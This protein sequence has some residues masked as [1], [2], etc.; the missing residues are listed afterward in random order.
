[1]MLYMIEDIQNNTKKIVDIN[2]FDYQEVFDLSVVEI[3]VLQMSIRFGGKPVSTG[4][5]NAYKYQ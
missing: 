4:H 5:F 2:V 3:Q 1:M